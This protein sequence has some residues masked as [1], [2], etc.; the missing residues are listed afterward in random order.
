MLTSQA[1]TCQPARNGSGV[2]IIVF[3]IH[4]LILSHKKSSMGFY[5]LWILPPEYKCNNVGFCYAS[6]A[7][8]NMDDAILTLGCMKGFPTEGIPTTQGIKWSLR[9]QRKDILYSYMYFTGTI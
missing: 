3:F 5:P 2:E 8:G 6:I 4:R 1:S 9:L 7:Y